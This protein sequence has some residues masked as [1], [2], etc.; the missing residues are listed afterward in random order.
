MINCCWFFFFFFL[1]LSDGNILRLEFMVP[2]FGNIIHGLRMTLSFDVYI[3]TMMS[4]NSILGNPD[5]MVHKEGATQIGN[6]CTWGVC[7]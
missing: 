4:Q 7:V 1:A 2:Y 6:I 5:E 3:Y